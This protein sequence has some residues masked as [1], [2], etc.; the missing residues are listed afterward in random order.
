MKEPEEEPPPFAGS[1]GRIYC[2]VILYLCCLIMLFY[3]FTRTW[4]S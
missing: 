4:N 1:W 2:G 3:W